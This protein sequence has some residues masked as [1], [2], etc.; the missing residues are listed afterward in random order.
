ML[1]NTN[2]LSEVSVPAESMMVMNRDTIEAGGSGEYAKVNGVQA[3]EGG[4]GIAGGDPGSQPGGA[5]QSLAIF[6]LVYCGLF[7]LRQ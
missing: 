5:L 6:L 4:R 2:K 7:I 1:K 3:G